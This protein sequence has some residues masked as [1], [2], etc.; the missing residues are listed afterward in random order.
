MSGIHGHINH[1]YEDRDLSFRELKKI[2]LDLGS[3]KIDAHEKIDGINLYIT[4]DPH[5][6]NIRV[7]RNRLRF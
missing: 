4:I 6:E 3:G 5:S 2:I 1:L 7:A